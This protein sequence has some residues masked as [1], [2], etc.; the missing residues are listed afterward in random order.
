MRRIA[1]Y[2][3]RGLL[4][5]IPALVTFYLCWLAI[6]WF[7]DLFGITTPG[8]GLA[9]ALVSIT[10][11]GAL[12]SNL[13]TRSMI[14]SFDQLLAKLPFVRLLYTSVKDLLS[15]FVG[16]KKRF[17][18]PVRARIGQGDAE[19][20]LLGFVTAESLGNLGPAD[21]VAVYVPFS[22]S[23]AGHILLLP[24]D[25]VTPL[26]ADAADAMAFIV[27]GGVSRSARPPRSTDQSSSTS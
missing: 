6:R 4:I 17:N 10:V 27:S 12:G 26:Q 14:A 18:R 20:S 13:V 24:R 25:R 1:N 22:Y 8:L 11:I 9:I 23:V 3:L 19:V 21:Q 16:E 15:A 2:F 5:T 7:D